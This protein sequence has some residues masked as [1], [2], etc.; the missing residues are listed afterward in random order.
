MGWPGVVARGLVHC[1]MDRAVFE[2]LRLRPRSLPLGLCLCACA[3]AL[4]WQRVLCS[5][6]EKLSSSDTR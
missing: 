3:S 1:A 5:L 4:A 2:R 6:D